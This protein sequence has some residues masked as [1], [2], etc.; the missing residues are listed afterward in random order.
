MCCI[1]GY[2]VTWIDVFGY[3]APVLHQFVGDR[4]MVLWLHVTIH[5]LICYNRSY[6][7]VLDREDWVVG[8]VLLRYTL[9]L[10]A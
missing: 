10:G 7:L 9:L 3:F 5:A 2:S 1:S 4:R 6:R 8:V